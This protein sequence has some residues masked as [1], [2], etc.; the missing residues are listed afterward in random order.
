[1]T[2]GLWLKSRSTRDFYEEVEL[3]QEDVGKY[4]I[5]YIGR[6]R[7]EVTKWINRWGEARFETHLI[8]CVLRTC[9]VDVEKM[10][11]VFSGHVTRKIRQRR[12]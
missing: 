7:G 10:R 5:C 3:A 11:D 6:R 4:H 12:R 1:M 2:Y 9:G 8:K